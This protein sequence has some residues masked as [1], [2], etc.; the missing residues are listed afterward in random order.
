VTLNP[1]T[2]YLKFSSGTS[3]GN[4]SFTLSGASIP[5]DPEIALSYN[6]TNIPDNNISPT[7]AMGTYFGT[8]KV[9]TAPKYRTYRITNSGSGTL[10]ISR[11]A[12][13]GT[14]RTSF[15]ISTQ[16]T[17]VLTPGQ[18]TTFKVSYSPKVRGTLI[19]TV[20]ITNDDP[21]EGRFDF[22]LKGIGQ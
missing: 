8:S 16:P 10:N 18:T 17:K 12:I 14:N 21:S 4:Y 7:T 3:Y 11:I 2:Y 20:V 22:R 13:E 6:S 19:A 1:G 5:L 9:G 15:K